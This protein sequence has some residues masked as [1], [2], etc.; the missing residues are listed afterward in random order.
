MSPSLLFNCP[1]WRAERERRQ[2]WLRPAHMT[3]H[4]CLVSM[5]TLLS[6]K[7]I[8]YHDLLPHVPSYCL[9][10][11]NNRPCPGIVLQSLWSSSQH[12]REL[13]SLSRVCRATARIVCVVLIP[14]SLSQVSFCTLQQLQMLLH[15]PQQFPWCGWGLTPVSDFSP[16]GW[17]SVCSCSSFSPSSFILLSF[18]WIYASLSK[19]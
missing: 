5:A 15:C 13:V 8:S 4:Y 11:V 3:Q 6:C 2:W 17:R 16:L 12:A 18:V 7:G 9:P 19:L 14:F 1:I 10:P